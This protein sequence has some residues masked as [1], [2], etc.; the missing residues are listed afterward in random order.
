MYT[1]FGGYH[2]I[3]IHSGDVINSV[4][5]IHLVMRTPVCRLSGV[6]H[7]F[8]DFLGPF[9]GSL[10]PRAMPASHPVSLFHS[11]TMVSFLG[12]HHDIDGA[13]SIEETLISVMSAMSRAFVHGHST[14]RWVN[15]YC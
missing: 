1:S 7:S 5:S 12:P 9:L 2:G 14:W 3:I 10:G 13:R 6:P 15:G 8:L 4:T 11:R